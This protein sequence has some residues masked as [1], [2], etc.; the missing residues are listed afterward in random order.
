MLEVKDGIGPAFAMLSSA[1]IL[2]G[3]HQINGVRDPATLK[4]IA[5][6]L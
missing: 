3:M 2:T 5:Q 1:G 6:D 4:A